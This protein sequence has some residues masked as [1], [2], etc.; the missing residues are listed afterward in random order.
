MG[1]LILDL[2]A[3]GIR[4]HQHLLRASHLPM[5]ILLVIVFITPEST[6]WLIAKGHIVKAQ[7]QIKAMEKINKRTVSEQTLSPTVHR[8]QTKHASFVDLFR[9]APMLFRTLAMFWQWVSATVSF[10][11]LLFASTSLA[12]SPY[13]NFFLGVIVEFLA[14]FTGVFLIDRIGR[15]KMCIVVQLMAG[16]CCLASGNLILYPDLWAL[17]TAFSLVGKFSAAMSFGVCYL[18]TAELYPTPLRGTAIGSCS[19]MARI[20]GI[21]ALSIASLSAVW[22]PLPMTIFGVIGV[23]AGLLAFIFPETTGKKLPETMEEALHIGKK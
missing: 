14:L 5:L 13:I 21:F 8:M 3:W 15:R 23:T 11:G 7:K 6:R 19:T 17:R 4:N 22:R 9:P 1:E 16:V 2:Q 12:G 10:Y 20:G 18:F